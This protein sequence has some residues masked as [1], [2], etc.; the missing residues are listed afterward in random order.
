MRSSEAKVFP[1]QVDQQFSRFHCDGL[2]RA[3]D[4]QGY[5]VT[6]VGLGHASS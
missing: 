1:D 2:A 6:V 3:V 4:L 5:D